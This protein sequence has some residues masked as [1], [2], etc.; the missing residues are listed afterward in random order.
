MLLLNNDHVA[1][2]GDD[3]TIKIWDIDTKTCL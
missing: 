2:T 3:K 1:T